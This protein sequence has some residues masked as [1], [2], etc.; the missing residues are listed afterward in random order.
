MPF[1]AYNK[2]TGERIDITKFIN[3]RN[4]LYNVLFECQLCKTQ[5]FLRKSSKGSFHF[6]HK[7]S[8]SC[9][10]QYHP[11]SPEHLAGKSFVANYILPKLNKYAFFNH[12]FEEPLH[13][14]KRIA[15]I[16][17]K[18]PMGW[19]IAHE[20]QLSP[21]TPDELEKRTIDYLDDGVDVMW[22][23]G[24]SADTESNRIWA[25][26]KYGFSLC[27]FF[28]DEEVFS[29]GYSE[30]RNEYGIEEI[31]TYKYSI[32]G[33]TDKAYEHRMLYIIGHWWLDLAFFRYYQVWKK[34]N[35]DKYKKAFFANQV[36]IRSFAGKIG[37]GNQNRFFKSGNMWC[38]MEN[39]FL[40]YLQKKGI[41]P[42]KK[43]AISSIKKKAI[44]Y[45]K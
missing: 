35:N 33:E 38:I 13:L 15:D 6:F 7:R 37:A 17:I 10:Y 4:E 16:V 42:L 34:G 11:E 36:T 20:I 39:E 41:P 26:N 32:A 27:L 21:I 28:E 5:M 14:V 25:I 29:Y 40:C 19:W 23:F 45:Q 44:M 18:F 8:C 12:L 31:K 9:D 1:I 43:V 3:P 24:K 22:W 30:K 2:Y